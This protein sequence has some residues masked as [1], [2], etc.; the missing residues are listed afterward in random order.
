MLFR[1]GLLFGDDGARLTVRTVSG[2]VRRVD[3][4]GSSTQ[5][6]PGLA[7]TAHDRIVA[8]ASGSAELALGEDSRV[9]IDEKS[10]VQVLS[11]DEKGVRLELEGGR[12]QA[13]IRPGS[14]R[15]GISADGRSVSSEDADFTVVRGEDGTVGVVAERGGLDVEGMG[16][17][18]RLSA[19]ER[20]VAAPDG[21]ALVAPA[22]EALLLAVDW[23]ATERTRDEEIE[24]RGHTEPGATVQVGYE[25]AWV[26]VRAGK[27]GTFTARTRLREGENDVEVRATSVLGNAL[28]AS[29]VVVRDTTAPQ[30]GLEIKY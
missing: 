6:V 11:A 3:G 10:S 23:P 12:V 17:R 25:G 27:D 15:L 20:L 19:G 26:T 2:D 30:L 8:G 14:G 18:S 28:S 13:T 5:A 22:D 16:D 24:V 4:L 1:S 9:R 29:H 21:G 7:L